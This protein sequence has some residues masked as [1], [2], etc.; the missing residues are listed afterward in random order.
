MA[1][2]RWGHWRGRTSSASSASARKK[3]RTGER[4]AGLRREKGRDD[5]EKGSLSLPFWAAGRQGAWEWRPCRSA[6]RERAGNGDNFGAASAG[7]DAERERKETALSLAPEHV[8]CTREREAGRGREKR[9]SDQE[10]GK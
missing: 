2:S 1:R 3:T 9:P 4:E 7:S 8:R 5:G 10:G 6:M